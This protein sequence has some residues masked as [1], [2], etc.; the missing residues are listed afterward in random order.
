[1]REVSIVIPTLNREEDLKEALQSILGQTKL[2]KEVIVVDDSDNNKTKGLMDQMRGDF[3]KKKI[4][5]KY[6]RGG[7]RKGKSISLARNIGM[8]ES[9]GDILLFIDD[10]VILDKKYISEILKVYERYPQ[11]LGVQGYIEGNGRFSI[12]SNSVNKIFYCT[13]VEKGK[14]RILPSGELT[15]PYS[16]SEVIECEWLSGTNS[17]YKK[18]VLRDFKFDEK[19]KEYS[20]W[21]DVQLS[22]SVRRKYV[23]SLYITPYARL[24]HKFSSVA[25]RNTKRL[26]YIRT[27]YSTYF[28]YNNMKQTVSNKIIF[29]WS[30]FGRFIGALR[31]IR[32]CPKLFVF[33]IG[34]Y[35]YTL[36]HLNDVINGNFTFLKHTD[37][38]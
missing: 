29:S 17:S 38:I 34:S 14:C 10:D 11:A 27:T 12:L 2:P 8:A 35:I 9:T 4:A 30:I 26:V 7:R 16:L 23:N 5:I 1:M 13:H 31:K 18:G 6:R 19:L 28:F 32:V 15:F 24:I 22:S 25:R 20:L 21:E 33:L 36:R 3:S 37:K